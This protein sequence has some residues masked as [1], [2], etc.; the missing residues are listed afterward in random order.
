MSEARNSILRRIRAH[1]QAEITMA[2]SI[3]VEAWLQKH[4]SGPRPRWQ[5]TLLDRFAE[6]LH[7]SGATYGLTTVDELISKVAVFRREHNLDG[8]MVCAQTPMLRSL[9]WPDDIPVSFRAARAGDQMAL[10]EAFC[11]VAETGSL[12]LHSGVDTPTT[13]NFLPEYFLC[14]LHPVRLVSWLEDVWALLRREGGMPRAINFITGPSRTADV[15]QTI[16]MGAHGPRR[17]HVLLITDNEN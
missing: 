16:Q 7:Q 3:G 8:T 9:D 15:E 6:K 4:T 17:V 1:R 12:V 2:E 5:K 13:L 14:V 11:A 10:S